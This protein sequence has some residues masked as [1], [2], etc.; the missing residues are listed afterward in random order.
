MIQ[1]GWIKIPAADFSLVPIPDP[2]DRLLIGL[3]VVLLQIDGKT[4]LIDTGLGDKW[5]I[6]DVS[7]IDFQR[8][9]SMLK[10][11]EEA[12]ITT[13]DV[14]IV[15]LTHLHYDHSGGGTRQTKGGGV[16]PTFT[17]AVYYVQDAELQFAQQPDSEHETDYHRED[18]EPVIASGQLKVINGDREILP[19]LSLHP[20]PGH[21]PGSQVVLVQQPGFTLFFPGDL[22]PVREFANLNTATVYDLHVEQVVEH[23]H[24]WMKKA[25]EGGWTCVFCHQPNNPVRRIDPKD[26]E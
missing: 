13:A 26:L 14:D 1:D 7:L 19:G 3:N 15:I 21:S 20:A 24:K 22:V 5:G 17:N 9:R 6:D 4:V 12:R 23:R 11:L 2:G 25:A 10:H 8:P 16:A 18:F